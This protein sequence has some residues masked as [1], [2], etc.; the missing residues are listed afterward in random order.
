M[1]NS[2]LTNYLEAKSNERQ[3]DLNSSRR[4]IEPCYLKLKL[5]AKIWLL[6]ASSEWNLPWDEPRI[7]LKLL[8]FWQSFNYDL[9]S[10]VEKNIGKFLA[11]TGLIASQSRYKG[12]MEY[13]MD[14]IEFLSLKDT[15]LTNL[16]AGGSSLLSW[17]LERGTSLELKDKSKLD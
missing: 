12:K 13:Q 1:D 9:K 3:A 15:E 10:T 11:V 2:N 8:S 14:F 16:E 7:E 17:L 5:C 4:A 6:L